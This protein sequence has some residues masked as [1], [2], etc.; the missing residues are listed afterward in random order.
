M[1]SEGFSPDTHML[2]IVTTEG[3]GAF[4]GFGAPFDIAGPSTHMNMIKI[5]GSPQ[6]ALKFFSS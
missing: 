4:K 1:W 3:V 2:A 6:A 5:R